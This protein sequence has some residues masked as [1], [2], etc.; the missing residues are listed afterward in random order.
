MVLYE[1]Q[2]TEWSC[3]YSSVERIERASGESGLEGRDWGG[4]RRYLLS[5]SRGCFFLV[6]CDLPLEASPLSLLLASDVWLCASLGKDEASA[7]VVVVT[8][9]LPGGFCTLMLI[10]DKNARGRASKRNVIDD[11][12]INDS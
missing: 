10:Y 11:K 8:S 2:G 6:S 3:S 4:A 12:R 9:A 7:A 5:G 1:G